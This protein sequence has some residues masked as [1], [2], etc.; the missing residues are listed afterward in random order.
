MNHSNTLIALV[1]VFQT[2]IYLKLE[3]RYRHENNAVLFNL[4][5]HVAGKSA[6]L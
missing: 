1:A 5:S 6:S 2:G 3:D 4:L